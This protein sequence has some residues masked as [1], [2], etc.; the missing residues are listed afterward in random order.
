MADQENVSKFDMYV[1]SGF[2]ASEQVTKLDMYVLYN[3]TPPPPP[4]PPFA[5]IESTVTAGH[6]NS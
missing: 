2:S 4:P 3:S 1:L 6:A 5:L